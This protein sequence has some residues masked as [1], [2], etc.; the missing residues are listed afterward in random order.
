MGLATPTSIMVG[1]GR[2]AEFGVLFRRGDALQS[3]RDIEIVAFDKTGT[4][5]AG[6]P[7][8]KAVVEEISELHTEILCGG[9]EVP[10]HICL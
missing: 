8:E 1:T 9:T 6:A 4:L 7:A 10:P 3:L 2:A 5:T